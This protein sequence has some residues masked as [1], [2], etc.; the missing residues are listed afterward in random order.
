[1]TKPALPANED[2]RLAELRDLDVLDTIPEQAYDDL[3]RI[4][5]GICGT[6]IGTVS[7]IDNDRQWFKARVGLTDTETSRDTAFC[8]HAI[9]DPGHLM[10]VADAT[11]DP[12]FFD[13]PSVTGDPHIRFYAGAPLVGPSGNA[14][15]TLCVIDTQP[16]ELKPFQKEALLGLSRQVC[17][18]LELRRATKRL[19]HQLQEREWYE[20]QLQQYQ[21][22][23]EAQNA[24]LAEQSRTDALTG[25]PNRRAFGAALDRAIEQSRANSTPLAVALIDADH[26]KSINDLHGH[27]AGDEVLV[28]IAQTLHAQ[29]GPNGMAARVGGE[30]FA[31]LVAGVKRDT[32]ELQ[33]EYLREAVQNLSSGLP[34]TVSIG[35]AIFGANDDARSLYTRADEALY[36][37]KRNGRNRVEI[38]ST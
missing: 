37:A 3:T 17:A 6:P 20:N 29:R 12:R 22:E 16:R 25:L 11:S 28:G 13:N 1:M 19:R 27:A 8:A 38:A 32:V 5:T 33:C 7:L 34:V 23:L 18:L 35:V 36:A 14:Y 31:M 30:E 15:G 24:E 9:N 21:Q 26:F 4:A 10:I 2:E